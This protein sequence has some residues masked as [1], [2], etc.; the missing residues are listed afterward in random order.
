M[1]GN[2][3]FLFY[4]KSDEVLAILYMQPTHDRSAL[5]YFRDSF[6]RRHHYICESIA[7][8]CGTTSIRRKQIEVQ[9]AT[10]AV[11]NTFSM[12]RPQSEWHSS[13]KSASMR[14]VIMGTYIT[15]NY[16][17]KH[18]TQYQKCPLFVHIN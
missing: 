10:S 16:D 4:F 7:F 1:E 5:G 15:L 11:T 3:G 6:E 2:R 9:A 8:S 18:Y 17:A 14:W 12:P 13:T